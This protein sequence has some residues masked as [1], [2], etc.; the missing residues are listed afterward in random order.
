MSESFTFHVLFYNLKSQ[1]VRYVILELTNG[2]MRIDSPLLTLVTK[3]INGLT[4]QAKYN[5]YGFA[6]LC[7]NKT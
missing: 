3:L 6:F 4:K 7:S 2:I 5:S 1:N